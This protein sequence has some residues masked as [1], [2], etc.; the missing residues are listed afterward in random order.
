MFVDIA[1]ILIAIFTVIHGR[2]IGFVRNFF[3]ATGFFFGVILGAW[4]Q[5]KVISEPLTTTNE[6]IIVIVSSL[7]LG[8]IFLTIGEYLGIHFKHSKLI[9][10]H[11]AADKY[12]GSLFSLVVL[13]FSLWLVTVL[14]LSVPF[15]GLQDQV[16]KSYVMQN[17]NR[18]LP[19]APILI[20]KISTRLSGPDNISTTRHFNQTKESVYKIIYQGCGQLKVGSGFNVGDNLI[21]TNAHVVAGIKNPHI[22]TSQK[23][24]RSDVVYIDPNLDFALLKA[25]LTDNGSL[26]FNNQILENESEVEVFGY[27]EGGPLQAKPGSINGHFLS[28]TKNIY[29]NHYT[30]RQIYEITAD[31]RS[32]DSG[33]PV[34]DISGRVAGMAFAE[35]TSMK[36]TGYSLMSKSLSPIIELAKSKNINRAIENNS[37]PAQ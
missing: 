32:G 15:S 37:C 1:I 8:L 9:T 31:V 36:N 19:S 12:L 18:V 28:K 6:A 2:D 34:L 22:Q 5:G 10:K 4:L 27:S 24:L 30:K 35:S 16:D 21:A 13:G 25:N 17:I 3:S 7:G 26:V 14:A 29:G 20:D 33:G 11:K 23:I